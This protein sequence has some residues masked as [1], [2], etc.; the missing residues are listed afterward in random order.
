M[1]SF[2]ENGKKRVVIAS[3]ALCMG[4]NFPDIRYVIHWGPPPGPKLPGG[5]WGGG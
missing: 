1:K 3:T 2:K 4:I 5:D